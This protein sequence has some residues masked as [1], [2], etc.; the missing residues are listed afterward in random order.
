MSLI[1]APLVLLHAV[2]YQ[3]AST[4]PNKTPSTARIDSSESPFIRIAPL[5]FK[6]QQP[7]LLPTSHFAIRSTPAFLAGLS[8]VT[9]GTLLRLTCYRY[10]G[11]LFTFDLTLLPKHTLITRGPYS[12]V[13]HPAYLGSILVFLGLGLADLSPGGW[14]AE[15]VSAG[16]HASPSLLGPAVGPRLATSWALFAVW[17]AWWLAVG[18]RR[19]RMEDA[20]LRKEFGREWDVYARRVRSWFV[21]GLL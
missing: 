14:V 21:P 16:D 5:I 9:A 2:L 7:L 13:R 1:R 17:F 19:A 3:L 20:T 15:C 4:P 10:L 6:I 8:L 18:V 11:A 12:V